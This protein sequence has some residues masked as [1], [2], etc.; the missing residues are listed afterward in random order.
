MKRVEVVGEVY[1]KLTV[2]SEAPARLCG[3]RE[4]RHL[5]VQC[6]C[7]TITEVG[8]RQLRSGNTTSC[9]CFRKEVTRERASSHGES[10][11]RLYKIW[12]GMRTRTI[13]PA[14]SGYDCYGGRGI[15]VCPDWEDYTT[16]QSWAMAN[17]YSD[18]LTIERND[19]DGDYTPTNCRWATRLEQANNRRPRSK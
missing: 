14:A 16:F 17:G 3:K 10:G 8:L 9:G 6:E 2:L 13:N 4:L 18:D 1:G 12:K 11:T 19:N 5:N 15:K 7:G